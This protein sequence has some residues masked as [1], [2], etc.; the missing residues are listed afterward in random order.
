MHPKLFV[1][2]CSHLCVCLMG[3]RSSGEG[4]D[5]QEVHSPVPP[6]ANNVSSSLLSCLEIDVGEH[7]GSGAI[8]TNLTCIKSPVF[9]G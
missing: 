6:S 2:L 7:M 5:I 8:T 1:C 4:W 3:M 9:K